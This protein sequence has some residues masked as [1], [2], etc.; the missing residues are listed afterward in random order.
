MPR[1]GLRDADRKLPGARAPA[2][3]ESIARSRDEKFRSPSFAENG[4]FF[5]VLSRFR[6]PGR[7]RCKVTVIH[8]F[9]IFDRGIF[10]QQWNANDRQIDLLWI[11]STFLRSA[12]VD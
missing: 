10:M 4:S 1:H 5:I 11:S 8:N 12:Y 7:D 3:V 2:Q 9:S 6:D